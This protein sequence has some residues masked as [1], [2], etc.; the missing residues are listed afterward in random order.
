MTQNKHIFRGELVLFDEAATIFGYED[1]DGS[2]F[3]S[4]EKERLQEELENLNESDRSADIVL[5]LSGNRL[6]LK[7]MLS[8]IMSRLEI[9]KHIQI[10]TG[11]L[12]KIWEWVLIN[13]DRPDASTLMQIKNVGY[14]ES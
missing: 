13:Y 12:I 14:T 9:V 7:L 3:L 8:D 5:E 10:L 2:S 1:E 11:S 6:E 4:M